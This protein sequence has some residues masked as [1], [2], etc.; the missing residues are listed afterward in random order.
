MIG[1]SFSHQVHTSSKTRTTLTS[2]GKRE[3]S[4]DGWI[5]F[6]PRPLPFT[7]PQY[8]H[9]NRQTRSSFKRHADA[10]R[11]PTTSEQLAVRHNILVSVASP[12]VHRSHEM[13]FPLT[14]IMM[15]KWAISIKA[16]QR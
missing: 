2:H 16:P 8:V 7:N 9:Q 14:K 11:L 12:K 1:Y 13:A 15:L 4:V 10:P 5:L 3:A 6:L